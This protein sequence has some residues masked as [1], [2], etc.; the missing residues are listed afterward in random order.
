MNNNIIT[1]K[2]VNIYPPAAE[3]GGHQSEKKIRSDLGSVLPGLDIDINDVAQ[4][5]RAE[6]K[7]LLSDLEKTRIVASTIA[8]ACLC[9]HRMLLDHGY[10]DD[11]ES[12]VFSKELVEKMKGAEISIGE[13]G[14]GDRSLKIT[15][16]A[17]API[18]EGRAV[19][20]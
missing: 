9:L 7:Q 2:D 10:S 11:G 12:I 4:W 8:N 17:K 15:S 5:L 20:E 16:R 14:T 19:D 6:N 3:F 18:W 1:P 13:T